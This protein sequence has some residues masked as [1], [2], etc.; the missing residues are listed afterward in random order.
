MKKI[1]IIEDEEPLREAFEFILKAEGF[2]VACAANGKEGLAQLKK[3]KP[4]L[5]LV[6]VLMPIMDGLEFLQTAKIHL[7]YPNTQV[8]VL[9]NLSDPVSVDKAEQF[10]I[11]EVIIKANLAPTDLV[12]KAKKYT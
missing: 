8:I 2:S 10:G 7:N 1:L 9:S 6:D 5:V 11:R 4:N 12:A 3:F